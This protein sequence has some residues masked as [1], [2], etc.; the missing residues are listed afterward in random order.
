MR[1][2]D[3]INEFVQFISYGK[4]RALRTIE[5][6]RLDLEQFMAFL[7][8]KTGTVK[9]EGVCA[10][11]QQS[12]EAE[13]S[14]ASFLTNVN[15]RKV[16]SFVS[17]LRKTNYS[18]A[19]IRRKLATLICFY[20]FLNSQH[21]LNYNPM[22][23]V[24]L[25][26]VKKHTPKILTEEQIWK[27]IH[28]PSL[29]SW[30][31]ARDRAIL[32]LLCNNGIRVSELI[33]LD[34]DDIDFNNMHISITS[35]SGKRR[36]VNITAVTAE[37]LNYYLKLKPDKT[38]SNNKVSEKPLFIN[39]FG[40]RLDTRSTD[41]RIE[42]YIRLVGLDKS[43]TP[44]DLRH[45]LAQKLLQQGTDVN[46]LHLLLGLDSLPATQLYAESLCK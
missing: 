4:N 2:C 24:K 34:M 23:D 28:I 12:N 11:Q 43:I 35:P 25:P 32:E 30:I 1:D 39:R 13:A 44:Y 46:E 16:T 19:S 33:H 9:A 38:P 31:G 27:L 26:K 20:K 3:L 37:T 42:K 10:A 18:Y 14:S 17:Y 6:Y 5:N 29:D 21:W 8:H 7:N 40:S 22:T 41:R 45:T 36:T 15:T